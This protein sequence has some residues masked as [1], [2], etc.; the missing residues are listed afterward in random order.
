MSCGCES[1]EQVQNAERIAKTLGLCAKIQLL[2]P[3][4]QQHSMGLTMSGHTVFGMDV[5]QAPGL[6][7]WG[8]FHHCQFLGFIYAGS[9]NLS[10][11]DLGAQLRASLDVFLQLKDAMPYVPSVLNFGG[12]LGIPYTAK[13]IPI[14]VDVFAH[15]RLMLQDKSDSTFRRARC[16]LNS[17]VILGNGIYCCHARAKGH[18]WPCFFSY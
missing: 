13:D 14:D 4:T 6:L 15:M 18:A 17:D 10:A 3:V 16:A 9:Q 2:N 8:Q 5:T 1:W 7:E 11:A 12:G